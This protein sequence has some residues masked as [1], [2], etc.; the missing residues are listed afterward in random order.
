[1]VQGTENHQLY[2]TY[3]TYAYALK[4]S[5]AYISSVDCTQKEKLEFSLS[6]QFFQ[7]KQYRMIYPFQIDLLTCDFFLSYTEIN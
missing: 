4:K 6:L 2:T 1:M 3:F 7:H 5:T